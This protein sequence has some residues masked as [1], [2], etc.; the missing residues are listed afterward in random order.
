MKNTQQF[1]YQGYKFSYSRREYLDVYGNPLYYVYPN[2]DE[3]PKIGYR[4]NFNRHYYLVQSYNIEADLQR[5]AKL[6][7]EAV[8]KTNTNTNKKG[9][10]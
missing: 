8:N 7:V 1:T 4:R 9:D 2:T 6:Y 3:L 5:L 10:N